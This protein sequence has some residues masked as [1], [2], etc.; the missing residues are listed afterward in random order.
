MFRVYPVYAEF[1]SEPRRANPIHPLYPEERRVYPPY[2]ACP[3]YPELRREPR[4][5]RTRKALRALCVLCAKTHLQPRPGP[6]GGVY[7]ERLGAFSSLSLSSFRNL[8]TFQLSNLSA[9]PPANSHRITSFAH[10]HPL[11]P[12]E[13]NLCKKQGGGVPLTQSRAR[14]TSCLCA[15][16]RMLATR[17]LSWVYHITRGHPGVAALFSKERGSIFLAVSTGHRTRTTDQ[18]SRLATRYPLLTLY[19]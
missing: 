1:R 18:G 6:G 14:R 17:I 11:I 8:Q 4:R 3:V 2:A 16:R 12:I 5:E 15:I 19:P 10:P 9:C 7:P 13:S